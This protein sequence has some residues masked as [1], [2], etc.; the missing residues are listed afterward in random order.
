[1][2]SYPKFITNIPNAAVDR[3]VGRIDEINEVYQEIVEGDGK[4]MVTGVGG[5]GK[6]VVVQ[7]FLNK[8][9][10]TPT[11][12]SQIEKLRGFLMTTM[13]SVFL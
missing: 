11:E 4:L 13:T 12:E 6:T 8:L 7:Q 10:N 1:M 9:Q 3:L 5:L 2:L